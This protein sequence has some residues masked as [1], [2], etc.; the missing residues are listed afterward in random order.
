VTLL[1]GNITTIGND[2]FFNCTKL[3]SFAI[4]GG[5]T[6]IGDHAFMYCT[7]LTR[8][9]IPSGVTSIGDQG[10]NTCTSLTGIYFEG[11][12][13]TPGNTMFDLDNNLT[14]YYLAG[15]AGWSSTYGGRPTALWSQTLT[16]IALAPAIAT[17]LVGSNQTFTAKG[18]DQFG[19]TMTMTAPAWSVNGGGTITTGGIFNATT[20]GGPFT[21]TATS[22][23]TNGMSSVTVVGR[24]LLSIQAIRS[25]AGG[26]G[27]DFLT[28]SGISYEVLWKANLITDT[29]HIYTNFTGNGGNAHVCFT[30]TTPQE[31]FQIQSN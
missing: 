13:P 24:P 6:S 28:E 17:V 20:A 25:E 9:T 31:F 26:H 29:W 5:V 7:S 18:A 12:A 16:T 1:P 23:G 21:V 15:K 3:K 8:V 30:N 4:P 2:M 22:G 11:N 27:I 10:F 19:Y 14:V